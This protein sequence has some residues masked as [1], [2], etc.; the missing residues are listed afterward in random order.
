MSHH[1]S[2][3]ILITSIAILGLLASGCSTN[4][5]AIE[6]ERLLAAAGFQM[7][8]AD[9]PDKLTR[10]TAQPQRTLVP[11]NQDGKI[12]YSYADAKV[13]KCIYVGTERAYGRYQKLALVHEDSVRRLQAAQYQEDAA[14]DMSTWGP[15]GPWWY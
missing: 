12:M 15:W 14:M 11:H 13:C 7:R 10:L 1:R 3:A 2:L 5:Q 8:L 9:T 4:S 6:T